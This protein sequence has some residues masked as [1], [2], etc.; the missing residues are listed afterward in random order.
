MDGLCLF[1]RSGLSILP[2]SC[3]FGRRGSACCPPRALLVPG[4]GQGRALATLIAPQSTACDGCVWTRAGRWWDAG[5]SARLQGPREA[6]LPQHAPGGCWLQIIP[7]VTELVGSSYRYHR[8]EVGG[9]PARP[10][11]RPFCGDPGPSC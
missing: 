2:L 11:A 3:V 8:G 10:R 9:A 1:S 4:E 6:R 7:L 5:G